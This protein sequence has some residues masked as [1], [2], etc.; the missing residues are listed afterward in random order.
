MGSSHDPTSL[1][2]RLKKR[3]SCL[4]KQLFLHMGKTIF[5]FCLKLSSENMIFIGTISFFSRTNTRFPCASSFL[6]TI[7][8]SLVIMRLST[9]TCESSG[10]TKVIGCSH[11]F[12]KLR[13]VSSGA[14]G[15]HLTSSGIGKSPRSSVA[16]GTRSF[17]T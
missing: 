4:N 7:E 8:S 10:A 9:S 5:P 13:S 12:Q 16:S 6:D 1:C 2:P 3:T 15:R 17:R 14:S 11:G